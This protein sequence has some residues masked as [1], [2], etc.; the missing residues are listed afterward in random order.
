MFQFKMNRHNGMDVSRP[1]PQYNDPVSAA[2]GLGQIVG[3]ENG[4]FLLPADD[5]GNV[6]TDG[7]PC[8]VIQGRERF[9]QQKKLRF[10]HQGADECRP[11]AHAAGQ[12]AGT[13]IAEG[14]QSI[15]FQHGFC[16]G[17]SFFCTFSADFQSQDD[18]AVNGTP[19][20]QVILLEHVADALPLPEDRVA[21]QRDF[22][23][24]RGKKA[25]DQVQ[26]GG[27]AAAGGANNGDKFPLF[28]GK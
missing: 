26:Q 21:F 28:Y 8:L 17:Q 2:D 25:A 1:F 6:I 27:F 15:L 7:K 24:F 19:L 5:G 14:G 16:P 11:L 9:V 20:E 3:D 22:P 13:G 18:I 12:F 4:R 23:G 10:Q